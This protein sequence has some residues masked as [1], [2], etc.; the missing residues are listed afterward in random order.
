[1]SNNNSSIT[2]EDHLF[3]LR[4]ISI[5]LNKMM[6][7]LDNSNQA[8]QLKHKVVF[9]GDQNVGKSSLILR[10]IQ[11]TFDTNYSVSFK[12]LFQTFDRQQ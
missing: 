4:L 8:A 6:N 2:T 3:L 9:L 5:K 1:M 7:T 12:T 11:D 10:F